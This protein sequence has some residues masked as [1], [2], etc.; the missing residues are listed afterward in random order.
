[1]S[2]ASVERRTG[3]FESNAMAAASRRRHLERGQER[4][5]CD[6]KSKLSEMLELLTRRLQGQCAECAAHMPSALSE[7]F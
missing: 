5:T 3:R 2:L 7:R 4:I 1:M 6:Y